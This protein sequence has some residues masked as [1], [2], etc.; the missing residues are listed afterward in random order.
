VRP[1]ILHSD[2]GFADA[3]NAEDRFYYGDATSVA[4]NEAGAEPAEE[5]VAALEQRPEAWIRKED[6]FGWLCL[7]PVLPYYVG[8]KLFDA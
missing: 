5:G 3:S 7:R 8:A 4:F 6:G 2:P 1:G